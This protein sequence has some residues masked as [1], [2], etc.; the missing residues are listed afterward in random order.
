VSLS[1][2]AATPDKA[3]SILLRTF[4][5]KTVSSSLGN[6]MY[7]SYTTDQPGASVGHPIGALALSIVCGFF[8]M[9]E[10]CLC[11]ALLR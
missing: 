4:V 10:S 8:N 5:D 9:V 6:L 2:V 11:D 1:F 3:V 7:V